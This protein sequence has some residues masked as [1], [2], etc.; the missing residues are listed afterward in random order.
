MRPGETVRYACRECLVAYDVCLAPT[1]EWAEAE[2]PDVPEDID[3]EPSCC[4]FCGSGDIKPLH[5]RPAR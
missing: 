4:P 5:D 1:S 2:D 3:Y